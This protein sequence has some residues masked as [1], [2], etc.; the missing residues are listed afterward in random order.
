MRATVALI[1]SMLAAAKADL[2]GG[3]LYLF[4]GPVPADA[5]DA[6]DMVTL[7]TQ[8]AVLTLDGEGSG[9]TFDAPSD[10]AL[11]KNALEEWSGLNVF[12]GADEGETVLTPTFFRFCA[13]GDNGR[14]SGTGSPRLQGS[15]GGPTSAA[16]A[17]LTSATATADGVSSTGVVIFN[18]RLAPGS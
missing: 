1:D 11:P 5:A 14:G 12:E 9:L 15:A 4:A 10:G 13:S 2:D 8:V 18:F 3:K 7:H 16:I 6:L 17:R